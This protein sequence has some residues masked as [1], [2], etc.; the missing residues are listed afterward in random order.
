MLC[1][2]LAASVQDLQNIL[3]L[4]GENMKMRL[5]P[6]EIDGEGF[7]TVRHSLEQ[8]KIMQNLVPQVIATDEKQL[9][10]YA[11]VMGRELKNSIPVLIPMFDLL[12]TLTYHS[13]PVRSLNYY[14]MGQI[15][16]RKSHRGRGVFRQLYRAHRELLSK[17]YDCCIT[18]VSTSNFRSM[19]AHLAVGF[20]LLHTFKDAF[21]EW[22]IVLWDWTK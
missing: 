15:C 12:D 2:R 4:Q 20:Q 18:E 3:E 5:T 10:G 7:I 21:Y 6:Q 8:L 11:L 14:V 13:R 16:V 1:V 19:R 9:A 17:D 22:N